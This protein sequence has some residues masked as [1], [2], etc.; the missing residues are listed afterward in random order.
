MTEEGPE[1]IR[2]AR[3][4]GQICISDLDDNFWQLSKTNVAYHT[5]DPK[6]NPSV[7]S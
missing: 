1:Q 4:E 7:Q 3:A 2:R 6:K 5:T